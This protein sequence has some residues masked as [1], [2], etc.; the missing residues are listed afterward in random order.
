VRSLSEQERR[1]DLQVIMEDSST[2]NIG[3]SCGCGHRG[4]LYSQTANTPQRERVDYVK[5][6]EDCGRSRA[7]HNSA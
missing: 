2:S 1:K 3:V 7:G 6:D 4:A 5:I